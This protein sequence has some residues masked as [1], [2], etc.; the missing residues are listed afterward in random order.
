[1]KIAYWIITILMVLFI[2]ASAIPDILMVPG[3]VEIIE[4][5]GYPRY[6]V[7]FLG[8]AKL[9]A[10]IAVLVPGFER[11]REWAYAGLV[12]DLVGAFYSHISVGDPVSLWAPSVVA[13][14]LVIGSYSLYHTVFGVGA[15]TT[16]RQ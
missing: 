11:L 12:I 13:L 16:A 6:L 5:L 3:A 10:V 7:P 4:H 9:L 2:T 15:V 8:V 14:A 1:M